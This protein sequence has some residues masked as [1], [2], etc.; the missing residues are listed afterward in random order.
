M[1]DPEQQSAA[2]PDSIDESPIRGMHQLQ[3]YSIR[4]HNSLKV[5]NYLN[6]VI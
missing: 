3:L 1:I 6:G 2:H 5:I 4:V